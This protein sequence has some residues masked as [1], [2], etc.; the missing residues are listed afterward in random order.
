LGTLLRRTLI[1]SATAAVAAATAVAPGRA[2]TV[3]GLLGQTLGGVTSSLGN[4]GYGTSSRVFARWLDLDGYSLAPEGDLASTSGWSLGGAAVSNDRDPYG[5][6][7]RSLSFSANGDTAVT[8]TMCVDVVNPAMRFFVQGSGY[9]DVTLD[10]VGLDGQPRRL[11]LAR[12]AAGSSWQ[13]SPL[14][15]IGANLLS[16]L[17][18]N[19][20]T[21]VSFE[22][23]AGGLSDGQTISADGLY[24]DPYCGR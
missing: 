10:F 21:P 13:P 5:D 20:S 12:V 6:S 22:L 4:C 23:T 18:A 3:G 8:P 14:I 24:V 2:G 17:S 1:V 9:L 15:L 7:A 11:P 19:G 16:A